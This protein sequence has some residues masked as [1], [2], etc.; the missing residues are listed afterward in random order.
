MIGGDFSA[1][2]TNVPAMAVDPNTGLPTSQTALD[3]NGNPTFVGEIFNSRLTE[4]VANGSTNAF[5]AQNPNGTCGFPIV[6]AGGKLNVF[7]SVDPLAARLSAFWP[8]PNASIAGN[9]FLSDPR[10]RET[11]NNFDIRIDHKINDKDNAF[12]RFSYEDQPSFI[13]PP[14][15]NVLDGGGFFDGIEDNSYRSVALSETHLFKSSLVNEFRVG[16]NRIN[17]HRFQLNFNQNV[18]SQLNFPGVPFTPINGGL[19]SITFSDGTAS[20]GSSGFLPSVEKQNSYVFTDN[21]TWIHGRHSMKYGTEVRVEQFTI[22][23]PAASRGTMDFGSQFTDNPAAPATGGGSFAS[24]LLGVPDN[25]SITSL[26]NIDYRRQIYSVYAQDDWKA[27]DRLTVNL[28]LRYEIFGTVKEHSNEE[29]TFD[30]NSVS[31]IVP[32][33]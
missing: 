22:F 30:F 11:R 23:Q 1:Q 2:L 3:C 31:L 5:A 16:Y 24:F 20:I 10:R 17:S 33:G 15:N 19:P 32:K 14:F 21:L 27:S 12:G 6:G 7:S 13:P 4:S 25:G 8:R 9:N 29:A 18:A 28:G 26:H